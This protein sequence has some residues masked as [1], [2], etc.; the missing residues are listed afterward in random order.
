MAEFCDIRHQSRQEFRLLDGPD[1][2]EVEI[3]WLK[4][5]RRAMT[6][7]ATSYGGQYDDYR[8]KIMLGECFYTRAW[9][10]GVTY[11]AFSRDQ[12]SDNKFGAQTVVR[13]AS[14]LLHELVHEQSDT[15]G[16]CHDQG[17]YETFH[18]RVVGQ[19]YAR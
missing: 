19:E 3:I 11:V 12:L 13:L 1:A 14:V 9:T 6:V 4:S 7:M 10:D 18:D 5:L 16:H 2:N 15:E 17:F 8:R